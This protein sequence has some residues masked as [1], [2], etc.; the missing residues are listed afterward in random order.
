VRE[1]L[2]ERGTR[3]L[4]ARV[5]AAEEEMKIAWSIK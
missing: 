2:S 4:A 1:K 5:E 3:G